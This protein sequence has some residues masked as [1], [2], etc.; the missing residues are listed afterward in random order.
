MEIEQF[1]LNLKSKISVMEESKEHQFLYEEVA[2]KL[3]QLIKTN[4]LKNGDKLLS[5]RSLSKEYG[6]SIS[7]AFKAYAELEIMGFVEARPKSGF[8]VNYHPRK[9]PPHTPQ[10]AF[11]VDDPKE[12]NFENHLS[13]F[14]NNIRTYFLKDDVN[15]LFTSSCPTELF[16]KDKLR[17]IVSGIFEE[18]SG[19]HLGYEDIQG[20]HSTMEQLLPKMILLP[21]TDVQKH[22]LFA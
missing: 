18:Q 17:N 9:R 1:D 14:Y 11:D 20:M 10:T 8:Y 13:A 19:N 2:N 7:T 12:V 4:V 16:P 6:I 3:Q 15:R 5:V 22:L 21:P